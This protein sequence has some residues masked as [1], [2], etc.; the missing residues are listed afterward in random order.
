MH[1]QFVPGGLSALRRRSGMSEREADALVQ[2]APYDLL[3]DSEILLW[4][5]QSCSRQLTSLHGPQPCLLQPAINRCHPGR[6]DDRAVALTMPDPTLGDLT[7]EPFTR[8]HDA[9]AFLQ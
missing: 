7:C 5:Q 4:R 1:H 9:R 6:G 3:P 8:R 2:I